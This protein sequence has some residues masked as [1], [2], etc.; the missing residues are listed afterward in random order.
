V[1]LT[2]GILELQNVG[3]SYVLDKGKTEFEFPRC[4][5]A[6]FGHVLTILSY[7]WSTV[8]YDTLWRPC[9]NPTPLAPPIAPPPSSLPEPGRVH[10]AFFPY[11]HGVKKLQPTHFSPPGDLKGH[12]HKKSC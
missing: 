12:S 9:L 6:V 4:S 7:Y 10:P 5:L 11:R 3:S 1:T 2:T 8:Q